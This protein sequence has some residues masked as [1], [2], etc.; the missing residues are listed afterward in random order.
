MEKLQ[1]FKFNP[2]DWVMG[3]IQRCPEITQARFMRLICL[4]WNKECKLL[5]EDA[6]IEIDKE[7]LDI[8][9]NKKIILTNDTF[10][11]ISFL[12]EQF[13]EIE[14][15]QKDK[16]K[17]G[18][19]GNLKRWHLDIYNKFMNKEISL[20]QAIEQ[21]KVIAHLSHTDCT[22][23]A[24][25]SQN[26]AEKRRG[27]E[28]REEERRED[29]KKVFKFIPPLA[30]DVK[31]YCISRNNNVN[32]NKF[33]DFYESKG[34]MIGKTKMKDWKACVRTW[35]KDSIESPKQQ[36]SIEQL[37][38]ENVMRQMEANK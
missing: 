4:Y 27:E 22:P 20:E 38:Y 9:I 26:I 31:A 25:Q 3:K 8:L 32:V 12:D 29:N 24:T 6:E 15:N 10:L 11:N 2:T 7:H 37:Q 17:S 36:K 19:I 18:V 21:S 34:W 35:E 33:I 1:W 28:N 13:Y 5:I 23:I 14:T 16:S 30:D